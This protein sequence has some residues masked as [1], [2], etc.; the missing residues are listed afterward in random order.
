MI[1]VPELVSVTFEPEQNVPPPPADIE[2][3]GIIE[4]ITGLR[5][6]EVQTP[7]VAST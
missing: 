4:A 7:S 2:A 1:F 6:A 3:A 5:A